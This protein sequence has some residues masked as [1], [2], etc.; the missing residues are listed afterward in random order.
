MFLT[1]AFVIRMKES[2]NNSAGPPLW[3]YLT[4]TLWA[5]LIFPQKQCIFLMLTKRYQMKYQGQPNKGITNIHLF[6]L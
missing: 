2:K 6:A 4:Y 5:I 3:N 1:Q